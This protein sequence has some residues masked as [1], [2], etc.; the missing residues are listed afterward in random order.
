MV[1]VDVHDEIVQVAREV[2]GVLDD[3]VLHGPMPVGLPADPSQV[4][5]K[6]QKTGS[7][8]RLK[9]PARLSLTN[10]RAS[11]LSSASLKSGHLRRLEAH[12]KNFKQDECQ[13]PKLPSLRAESL[14]SLCSHLLRSPS[15]LDLVEGVQE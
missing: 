10:Q 13:E 1:A 7:P 15:A 9:R 3:E 14:W 5:L 2:H 4:Q 6:V 12:G 11:R 8:R